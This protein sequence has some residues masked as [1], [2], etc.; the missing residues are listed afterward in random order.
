MS[1]LEEPKELRTEVMTLNVGPQHPST[2]GVLRLVIKMAGEEVLEVQPHVGYLH[3]GFEKNMEHRTYLQNITY[4][5]RMDYLHSFAHDLAYALAVER[6]VGAEVP[7]RAQTI[8]IILNELSR[9]ASHLVF[10]GTGLLDFGALTPFFYCFREREA[11][12]DL[13]EWVSGQRFHHNY[14]RIGGLKNDLPEEFIPELKKFLDTFDYRVDEYEGMFRESPIFYER[15]RDVGVIPPEVAIHLGLTGGSLR[16]S[17]VNYDVR[18][19]YPYAGYETYEFD[20]PLG[21]RGDVYDRMIV[22]I[23]EMR[24]SARIIRQAVERLEPGPIRDPNPQISLPPRHLLETSMEAV[25]YHFKLVTEGFHPP[26]GEVYVPTESARG[27]LG[28]YIISDG[29]SM[30]Y[31][32]K[33]RAPSFVNL[34]SLPYACEGHQFP[35]LVAILASLDPVMGD[36]DR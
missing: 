29:G 35:D 4:T 12:L 30:P 15:A 17:G 8:R 16:A 14:I 18:K 34:Q 22:R 19:A 7:P 3:T 20:V 2:H 11:I 13:F 33:V 32:V 26:K 21:E 36:V 10:T 25:I 24:E 23:Q 28:Y 9:I 31:R 6:L 5:P 27:E 1:R